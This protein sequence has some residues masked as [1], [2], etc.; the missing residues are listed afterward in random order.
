MRSI[1]VCMHYRCVDCVATARTLV[2]D[3]TIAPRH[4]RR[5]PVP[6]RNNGGTGTSGRSAV[7]PTHAEVP[8]KQGVLSCF[9]WAA[10]GCA[11]DASCGPYVHGLYVHSH[12]TSDDVVAVPSRRPRTPPS[13]ESR[14]RCAP[15]PP[16]TSPAGCLGPGVCNSFRLESVADPVQSFHERSLIG[17]RIAL[18]P[19][20][21]VE[22]LAPLPP[23]SPH[24]HRR[25]HYQFCLPVW[26]S[27]LGSGA[28]VW[29]SN[30]P[31]R[32][33]ATLICPVDMGTA[34][35]I[36][37]CCPCMG[38]TAIPTCACAYRYMACAWY[39]TC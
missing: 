15:T 34:I 36:C 30:L 11:R 14:P 31:V 19:M 10:P 12:R 35:A 38:T 13:V 22:A 5:W 37:G 39:M 7:G 21:Q 20:P 18:E 17:A 3:G 29:G 25:C 26:G 4:V 32:G 33:T 27:N 9:P 1:G 28:P 23:P 6:T 24:L 2:R 16:G 8:A